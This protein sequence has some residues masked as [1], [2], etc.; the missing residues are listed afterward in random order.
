[1]EDVP[2][3]RHE[4]F[5]SFAERGIG[6]LRQMCRAALEE[7]KLGI[8]FWP[9]C[10]KY[11]VL[12]KN[13]LWHTNIDSI[14]IELFKEKNFKKPDFRRFG[15]VCY[16]KDKKR[17]K[18]ESQTKTCLFLGISDMSSF[19]TC[20]LFVIASKRVVK[21][22]ITD[23]I[24]HESKNFQDIKLIEEV[25]PFEGK[26]VPHNYFENIDE[27]SY[28]N[29][30]DVSVERN[31]TNSFG[32]ESPKNDLSQ[33]PENFDE[34]EETDSEDNESSS[35]Q[36]ENNENEK[37]TVDKE[38]RFHVVTKSGRTATSYFPPS[39]MFTVNSHETAVHELK[40]KNS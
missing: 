31:T 25:V 34:V 8:N 26:D 9:F 4:T 18:L 28:I 1:M 6:V 10:L 12:M 20:V 22:H 19:S 15:C 37:E 39:T 30:N 14:P 38:N 17:N 35:D 33:V 3:D 21:R 32:N 16:I 5:N 36:L 13:Y 2:V 23:V 7:A 27:M 24:F 40:Q 29:E 11:A